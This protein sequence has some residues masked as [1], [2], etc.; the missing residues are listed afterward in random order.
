MNQFP[1]APILLITFNRP[2]CTQQVLEQLRIARVPKLYVFNDAP[3]K[4]NLNDEEARSAIRMLLEGIDWPCT[5]HTYFP[6]TNM[7]CAKGV[8]GA[9]SWIFSQE[10]K[11]I[12]L[13]DDT[14]PANS[15]FPYCNELLERYKDDSRVWM[16]SGNNYNETFLLT[17]SY[18]FSRSAI[19]IWGWATWKRS[20]AQFNLTLEAWPA[21]QKTGGFTNI[22]NNTAE[23]RFWTKKYAALYKQKEVV[24]AHTWDYQFVLSVLINGGLC[25]VPA[26]NLVTNIGHTGAHTTTA[27]PQHNK[28]T[29]PHFKIEKHPAFILPDTAYD[30]YHVKEFWMKKKPLMKRVGNKVRKILSNKTTNA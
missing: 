1:D 15:F 26:K 9:I 16:I 14:V 12:I 3:R 27:H 17:N 6:E 8:S 22:F 5:L 13:E 21:F 7:G 2:Q 19:H 11:A 18:T 29:D 25:V 20:W 10:E 4:G 30:A 28:P 24:T 23:Q